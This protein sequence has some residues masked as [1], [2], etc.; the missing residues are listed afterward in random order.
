MSQFHTNSAWFS[1][2]KKMPKTYCSNRCFLH[3]LKPL[4]D[5]FN[6]VPLLLFQLLFLKEDSPTIAAL[7]GFALQILPLEEVK[8]CDY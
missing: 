5:L 7:V 2:N 1:L 6:H 8:V 3:F 4:Q